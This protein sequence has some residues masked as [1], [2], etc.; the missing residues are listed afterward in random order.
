VDNQ[1]KEICIDSDTA[2]SVCRGILHLHLGLM[3]PSVERF[4]AL[5]TE[6][7][8]AVDQSHLPLQK[9][10]SILGSIQSMAD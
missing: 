5:Q 3:F 1:P 2:I 8:R 4:Q 7:G 6:I 9:W 10:Q